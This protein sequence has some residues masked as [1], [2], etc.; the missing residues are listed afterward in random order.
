M[1]AAVFFIVLQ[2]ENCLRIFGNVQSPRHRALHGPSDDPVSFDPEEQLWRKRKNVVVGN[3][4]KSTVGHGLLPKQRSKR[5]IGGEV[6]GNAYS[7]GK[8]DLIRLAGSDVL[9]DLSNP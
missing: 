1:F 3:I 4:E 8:I 7:I 6:S 5:S 9:L 2:S